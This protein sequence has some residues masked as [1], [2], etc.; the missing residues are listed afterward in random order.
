MSKA[1]DEMVDFELSKVLYRVEYCAMVLG[2]L[3]QKY[4]KRR[5]QSKKVKEGLD[6]MAMDI[7][8][9]LSKFRVYKK[10][11]EPG[12]DIERKVKSE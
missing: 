2:E 3:A 6:T 5:V 7:R 1:E 11:I 8:T 4:K 10:E 12:L 9:L